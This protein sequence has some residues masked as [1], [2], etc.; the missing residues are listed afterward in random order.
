MMRSIVIFHLLLVFLY[1]SAK[2][3]VLQK[4]YFAGGCFWG[5]EYHLEKLDGVVS[6]V[7]GYMGGHT[8]NP[9]YRDVIANNTGHYESVEVTFDPKRVSYETIARLFLKFMIRRNVTGK[10]PILVHNTAQQC[11]MPMSSSA[12]KLTN[13]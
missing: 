13:L 2:E 8:A 11:F 10:A 3:S 6:V 7:S 5:V 4:A 1:G 9:T 12:V